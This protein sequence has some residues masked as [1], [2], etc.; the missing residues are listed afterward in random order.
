M[1]LTLLILFFIRGMEFL[2]LL[3]L[4]GTQEIKPQF[5]LFSLL[6][7]VLLFWRGRS[8]PR[9][10]G[11][12]P[13]RWLLWG[14]VAV[15][16]G[17][18]ILLRLKY[19]QP[20]ILA[21]HAGLTVMVL[22]WF[23]SNTRRNISWRLVISFL[24]LILAVSLTPDVYMALII[25]TYV[26]MASLLL[27]CLY[28]E[29][30]FEEKAPA[31]LER[32]LSMIY[33]F[34]AGGVSLL[35][36][37]LSLALF[38]ILPR[39]QRIGLTGWGDVQ[40][41]YSENVNLSGKLGFS[42]TSN[43]KPVLRIFLPQ[44]KKFEVADYFP[45]ALI[46]GRILEIFDG[47]QWF[48]RPFAPAGEPSP[49]PARAQVASSLNQP[50]PLLAKGPLISV[51]REPLVS[52][53][54]PV[55][56]FSTLGERFI[57]DA[58]TAEITERGEWYVLTGRRKTLTY[59]F[60]PIQST[61]WI[62]DM[63]SERRRL[64]YTRQP[65]ANLNVSK[66][67]QFISENIPPGLTSF[68]KIRFIEKFF[69]QSGKYE[70]SLQ[71]IEKVEALEPHQ[72]LETFL[73]V[74]K[75]GH[76]EH[77]A[78]TALVLLRM[79]NIPTRFVSGFRVTSNPVAG[80]I[81]IREEDAHAWVEAWDK[82][83][84]WIALDPTPQQE[85]AFFAPQAWLR[86]LRDQ[87]EGNWYRYIV[88]FDEGTAVA[89]ADQKEYSTSSDSKRSPGGIFEKSFFMVVSSIIALMLI[90]GFVLF[91][92]HKRKRSSSSLNR[93]SKTQVKYLIEIQ[94]RLHAL[95]HAKNIST[96]KLKELQFEY[97]NLRFNSLCVE[98]SLWISQLKALKTQL[99]S[100][101]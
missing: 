87:V 58:G 36:F 48:G 94:R 90:C 21:S 31:L 3:G 12:L 70:T 72:N 38:P 79:M 35:I 15:I 69:A 82:E 64:N 76:C 84:G 22:T 11:I 8:L 93:L 78:S 42:E 61:H 26:V 1:N 52:D 100:Y 29:S 83:R 13:D 49:Q 55:P 40:P 99:K 20:V 24:C 19:L 91:A 39:P 75:V 2:V 54:L 51:T 62:R 60:G 73:F 101:E 23:L 95:E 44:D 6:F 47:S 66:W 77:F 9:E 37:I 45:K 65:F 5:F 25:L 18:L 7:S 33:L 71:N 85:R 56:Y 86:N 96:E 10:R 30:E 80:V 43:Q 34:Q 28:L 57:Q 53:I 74:R 46:R 32:P 63:T 81:T 59:T 27:F 14:F 17:A 97:K 50:F 92:R 68:Q 67:Q 16:G 41:G 88:G 4:W 89:E 98:D